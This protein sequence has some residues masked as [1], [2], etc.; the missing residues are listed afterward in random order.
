MTSSETI[1]IALLA[2]LIESGGVRESARSL[3]L[4][5][6]HEKAGWIMPSGRRGEWVARP[7]TTIAL[8][9]RL[10]KLL[11]QWESDFALLRTHNLDPRK[12]QD[13][14]ALPVLRKRPDATGLINRRNWT[15]AGGLGPKRKGILETEATLTSDWVMR[16]RPNRGLV[17]QWDDHSTDLWEMTEIWTECPIPQRLWMQF[18]GFTGVLPAV[19][20]TCENLGVFIDLPMPEEALAV[21]SPGNHVDPAIELIKMLPAA[22][23]VH[24]GDLD[25]EGLAIAGQIA[26][27]T[28][29]PIHRYIPS[30]CMEYIADD[31]AQ[32]KD[33][34]WQGTFE[35]PVLKLLAERDLGVF[36]EVFMLDPRLD[37]DLRSFCTR[38]QLST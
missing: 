31:M 34:K 35:H 38:S 6:R 37:E 3:D 17:A 5:R 8:T 7:E 19:I 1:E 4:I 29:C 16:L 9:A 14:E 10:A 24:F 30:F 23:W 27:A 20:I 2:K 28:R 15:A 36:Q 11:P 13:I 12:P 18:Q 22:T 33:V 21:F 25:P 32:K 26:D